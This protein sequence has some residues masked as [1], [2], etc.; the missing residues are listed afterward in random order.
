M[1]WMGSSLS[2]LPCSAA[3]APRRTTTVHRPH[4]HAR[5]VVTRHGRR[6]RTRQASE[7]I[8]SQIVYLDPVALRVVNQSET[9][10]TGTSD[11][12]GLKPY[13]YYYY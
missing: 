1:E 3:S 12:D 2:A 13:Y 8:S 10:V 7:E 6:I 5:S 9:P 11:D 4:T